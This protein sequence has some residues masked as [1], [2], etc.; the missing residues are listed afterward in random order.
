MTVK[1]KASSMSKNNELHRRAEEKIGKFPV[2]IDRF[3]HDELKKMYH[4]LLIHQ[5]EQELQNKDF[6]K[7]EK[8]RDEF[9]KKYEH[10]IQ[11]ANSIILEF[12]KDGKIIFINEYARNF[13]GY[14]EDEVLGK[15]VMILVPALESDGKSLE[16]LKNDILENPENFVENINENVLKNGERVWISWRNT[17]IRDSRG[18]VAGNFAV[19]QDVTARKRA[20]DE[21]R[22]L[23][24]T[25]KA[26][27][28]SSKAMMSAADES[29]YLK[30]V[31]RIIVEDC[32]FAM[33]WIGY[34]EEDQGKTVRPV[35]SAGFEEGYLETL[36]LTW[37]DT[38][39]GRGPT[40]TAIR[41][42]K[43]SICRNMLTDP[44]FQPWREEAV[45]RGY[46][47]SLVVPVFYGEK[48]FGAINIYSG[49]PDPFTE[50]EVKLFSELAADVAHG[51][52]VI[53]SRKARE[54]AE[55][56][57][58]ESE[59]RYRNLFNSLIEGYCI[60]EMIF[61]PD[62]RPVDYRFLEVNSTFE[63]QTGLK[64]VKGKLISEVIPENETYWFEIYGKVA[65][66]GE[67]VQFD[68]ETKALNRWFAVKAFRVG[69]QESRK[70]AICFNDITKRK[71][72]EEALRESEERY[73]KLVRYAPA[74]IYEMD[75]QG[76]KFLSVNDVMCDILKYSKKELLS[77]KPTELMDE[78]S[79]LLF[80]ERIRRKLA[81]EKLDET[82]EYRIRRKDGEWIYTAINVGA[83]T[84]TDEKNSRVVVIGHDITERKRAE[85][86]VK[87]LLSLVQEERDRLS[88]LLDSIS[89][90]VWFADTNRKFTLANPSAVREFNL[91]QSGAI[92][93]EK[94]AESLEVYRSDGSLRPV[95]EAPP[96]RA[97]KG[98]VIR[99][100]EEIIRTPGSGE[101]RNRQI[102]AAP[103]RDAS[104]A[105]IG[106]VSVVRDITAGKQA[107]EALKLAYENLQL[108]SEELHAANEEL[109]SQAEELQSQSEELQ[110]QS[111]ELQ[112]QSEELI[113]ANEE[114]NTI[115]RELR[116][117]RDY[118][119][120]LLGYANAP[121]IVW[122]PEMQITLF[123]RA[124]EKLT[125]YSQ[126][127]VIG[128]ELDMLFPSE[129]RNVIIEHISRTVGGEYLET[130]EIPILRKDGEVR[131][132]LWNS[133]NITADGGTLVATIAQGQDITERKQAEEKIQTTLRRFYLI[134]SSMHSG[135]LLVSNEDR[136][137]FANQAFCDIFGLKDS[138]SDLSKLSAGEM[139]EKIRLAYRNPDE[140]I[141]RIREIVSMGQP[142]RGE[143]TGMRYGQSLLRDFIPIR[144]GDKQFGRLWVHVDITDRKKAEEALRES[145]ERF[146]TIAETV[147]VLVCITRNADSIVMFTNEANNK[148]F[149]LRGEEIIGTKGPDYYCDPSDR[150]KMIDMF[151]G[152]GVINN[153]PLKVKK[154]DGTPFWIMTSVR[155]VTYNGHPAMVGASID[156]TEYRKAEEALRESELRLKYHFENSPLAVV[157]WDNDFIVTQWSSE[158]ERIFGW[159]KEET[160]GK[161]IDT[162]NMIYNED[163]PIV[164]NTMERLTGG[165]ES[166]V[167]SSNRNYTKAGNVIE[168]TWYNSV[169]S[170]ENGQMTSVMSLVL[171]ITERRR[172]EE[173]VRRSLD[174]LTRFN[175]A[176]VGR[177][178]RMIGLKKQINEL[179]GKLD[180]PPLYPLDF[181]KEQI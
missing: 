170:D 141:A 124:F 128:R 140:A 53:R 10:L 133:A 34:A 138:P 84:Y 36:K 75:V 31:C 93:V 4:E 52:S 49:E 137:E 131:I 22:I 146:R 132:A 148:A 100:E 174:E 156:I 162:L 21:L 159:K 11:N 95:D 105:I 101:L 5:T 48:V 33:V 70:V 69:G 18:N 120:K 135:I 114:T 117:T 154:S 109:Q 6:K 57:L 116:E 29:E 173:E 47:S 67:P 45:K 99:G 86:E 129:N 65:V 179:R 115:N 79:R 177:E 54:K 143:E 121:V 123:N 139:I 25:L 44:Q 38:E 112:A 23:N 26:L 127:E 125:G 145:E 3:S 87:R 172:A 73:K 118:L 46:A 51:I 160:L 41:T 55:E 103:V 39:R 110:T 1:S 119:D 16:T 122:N 98:E 66:T 155:P 85:E 130:V 60:I 77:I 169:L 24:C 102:S 30:E 126:E 165:K 62:G 175:R 27:S 166:M 157:E 158:A 108:Q 14:K 176:M 150:T 76:T 164:N 40:G 80:K 28:D 9:E 17:A 32:G 8:N 89:D 168:C 82:A 35:S 106:S 64:N 104:G 81:G 74:A 180:Q 90:E 68:N 113:T 111:E 7:A 37:A 88:S 15:D 153:Y 178:L 151:K 83:I 161:R 96:L 12:D 167:V 61:D 56:T 147:P 97:L 94:L 78:E 134:L 13:F 152:K 136:I 43:P 144:L 171:D 59:E 58:Q 142:V 63:K 91:D 19:G 92:D 163:I 2:D 50:N 149:G 72:A 20:A 71:R 107:E 181:E 42:G